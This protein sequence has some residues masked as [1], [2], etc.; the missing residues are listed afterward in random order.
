MNNLYDL[1]P[2]ITSFLPQSAS[3]RRVSR[4][5]ETGVN[6]Q[7]RV[8]IDRLNSEYSGINMTID[9]NEYSTLYTK[10]RQAILDGDS[11]IVQSVTGTGGYLPIPW[12]LYATDIGIEIVRENNPNIQE[13]YKAISP[14]W[15]MNA[16]VICD[17]LS[18]GGL[19]RESNIPLKYYMPFLRDHMDGEMLYTFESPLDSLIL[20]WNNQDNDLPDNDNL[21]M[22]GMGRYFSAESI[23]EMTIKNINELT[24]DFQRGI[25]SHI[26]DYMV[27]TIGLYLNRNV[28]GNIVEEVL[29]IIITLN[30]RGGISDNY[31]K[32]LNDQQYP[33]APM[34][35][36]I[37]SILY[38]DRQDILDARY[39]DP[40]EMIDHLLDY[41]SIT[42]I[43]DGNPIGPRVKEYIHNLDINWST[44]RENIFTDY[45]PLIQYLQ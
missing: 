31:L 1:I 11:E 16:R 32:T 10:L 18:H 38:Y 45:L 15:S 37:K 3:L 28:E 23:A 24:H 25:L 12:D 34:N 43:S 6:I 19:N 17:I 4:A 8:A 26:P 39:D 40:E 36:D 7:Q 42:S 41:L 20:L 2:N 22:M 9:G 30:N 44:I 33:F 29:P 21:Y 35:I 14:R 5:W 13:I 27:S